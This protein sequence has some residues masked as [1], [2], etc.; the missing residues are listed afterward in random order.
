MPRFTRAQVEELRSLLREGRN[1]HALVFLASIDPPPGPNPN[2]Y[3][4]I[5]ALEVTA[6]TARCLINAEIGWIGHLVQMTEAEL[7]RFPNF[8]RKALNDVKEALGRL[9]LTLGMELEDWPPGSQQARASAENRNFD[10]FQRRT[11]T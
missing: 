9:G 2:I 6:R 7:L 5:D 8:G 4:R 1:V 11:R 3:K 10:A